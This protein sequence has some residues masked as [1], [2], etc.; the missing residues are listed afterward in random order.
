[1]TLAQND[2]DIFHIPDSVR[3]KSI[4]DSFRAHE[5]KNPSKIATNQRSSFAVSAVYSPCTMKEEMEHC[6][7]RVRFLAV[8]F[9]FVF[10]PQDIFPCL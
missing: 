6:S 7:E 1:V 5:L 8:G 4:V 10:F 3:W 2:I 9:P